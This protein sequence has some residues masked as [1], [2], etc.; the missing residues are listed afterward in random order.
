MSKITKICKP[1]INRK[2][3]IIREMF[4]FV[5]PASKKQRA[6]AMVRKIKKKKKKQL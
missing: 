2:G 5:S 6:D 1:Q 3:V 4:A